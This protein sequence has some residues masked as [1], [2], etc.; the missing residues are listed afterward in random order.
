[1]SI[2]EKQ[3]W[4]WLIHLYETLDVIL[5]QLSNMPTN[6]LHND[7][8]Y[9]NNYH[10]ITSCNVYGGIVLVVRLTSELKGIALIITV[11]Y[12]LNS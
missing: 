3:C 8:L 12:T 9:R 5:K 10:I 2:C 1:M 6:T 11:D 7:I 4:S